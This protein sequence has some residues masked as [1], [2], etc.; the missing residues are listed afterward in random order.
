[1][2]VDGAMADE[3]VVAGKGLEAELALVAL[4]GEVVLLV[5]LEVAAPRKGL[6][7]VRALPPPIDE[8]LGLGRGGGSVAV[9]VLVVLFEVL[10]HV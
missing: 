5:A 6:V 7:A 2:L 3:D 1:M 10:L 4:G 8:P 9:A